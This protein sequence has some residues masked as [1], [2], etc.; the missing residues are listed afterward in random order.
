MP[1]RNYF[2][3]GNRGNRRVQPS[4]LTP[5]DKEHLV[6]VRNQIF[7]A[8]N[9]DEPTHDQLRDSTPVTD[10]TDVGALGD[11]SKK[12]I[13]QYSLISSSLANYGIGLSSKNNLNEP[14]DDVFK[15]KFT[16]VFTVM[17]LFKNRLPDNNFIIN[18]NRGEIKPSSY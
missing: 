1:L 9:G 8:L 5:K 16:I 2:K 12:R 4:E 3:Y 17:E 10:L 11:I 14:F 15:S 18:F 7:T 13:S 6:K